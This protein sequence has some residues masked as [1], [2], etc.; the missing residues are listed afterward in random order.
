[1][2][3]ILRRLYIHILELEIFWKAQF[4]DE[5]DFEKMG[6]LYDSIFNNYQKE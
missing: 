6:T 2:L 3:R 5:L 4:E 1:M